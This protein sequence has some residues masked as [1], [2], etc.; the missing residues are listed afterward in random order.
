MFQL[1]QAIHPN[2][3][4]RQIEALLQ[5]VPEGAIITPQKFNKGKRGRYK[6]SALFFCRE[7]ER[8]L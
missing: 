5:L 1:A 4:H 2:L 8:W 7:D 3:V 6:D